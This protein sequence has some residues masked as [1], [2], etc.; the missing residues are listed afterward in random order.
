MSLFKDITDTLTKYGDMLISETE[1]FASM[2]RLSFSRKML[3]SDL[4]RV[5][6][7][8][9]KYVF[10]KTE[11]G[12][13]VNPT[14]DAGLTALYDSARDVMKKIAAKQKEIDDLKQKGA[15]KA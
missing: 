15:G 11:K 2:A 1:K 7:K 10:E 9:G 6:S 13:A 12:S 3:E 14:E 4:D 8:I 5:M